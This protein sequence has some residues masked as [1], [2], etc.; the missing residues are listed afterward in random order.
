MRKKLPVFILLFLC[1]VTLLISTIYADVLTGIDGGVGAA[2]ATMISSASTDINIYFGGTKNVFKFIPNDND[3]YT[4]Q[5]N[6]SHD[7]YAELYNNP[8]LTGPIASDDDTG[9]GYNPLITIALTKDTVYYLIIYDYEE[10]NTGTLSITGI[11]GGGL[12]ANNSPTV[13]ITNPTQ[14][15]VY[16]DSQTI[17][18]SG[19]ASDSDGDNV[20][21]SATIN[22]QLA[23]TTVSGGSGTWTLTWNTAS[24]AENIYNNIEFTVDDSFGGSGT[25][26]YTGNITVDKTAPTAAATYSKDPVKQGDSLTITAN[27]S[28]AL[29]DSPKVKIAISGANTVSATDMTKVSET[30]YTYTYTVGTGNG[31]ATV[32]FSTGTDAAG[33]VITAAPTGGANYTI[34]NTGPAAPTINVLSSQPDTAWNDGYLNASEITSSR[35]LRVTLP[36]SGSLAV[37]GDTLYVY[38]DGSQIGSKLLSGTEITNGYV[39]VT[40]SSAT[41][42]GLTEATHTLTAKIIDSVGNTGS[43]SAGVSVTVD[44]TALTAAVTYSKNPVKQGDSLTITANFSKA[45]LDSPVVKIA[46][47]GANTVAA[48]D[49]TKVSETQYTYIYSVGAG[50]GTATVSFSTGTDA[51]GNVIT[52]APTSGANYTIDNT[53][54]TVN[55]LSPENNASS[56]GVTDNLAI[57]FSEN[58]VVGTGNITIKKTT[59]DSTVETIAVTSGKVTGGG[60]S[61]I[62]INP[63]TILAGSTSYYVLI[64]ATTF[65][66]TAGNSYAGISDK[67][68][69]SFITVVPLPP[70]ITFVKPVDGS[71]VNISTGSAII[72][73]LINNG[74]GIDSSSVQLQIDGGAWVN[75]TVL[76]AN[77]QGYSLYYV[78]T[79]INYSTNPHTVTVKV[80]DLVGNPTTKTISFHMDVRRNGFG[81]GRLRFD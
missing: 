11:T 29:L 9:V 58:V 43:T 26:S 18:I 52:G 7:P 47:G 20:S 55:A 75:P 73:N 25:A 64:D 45:L 14:D 68:T 22:G 56:V 76:T 46:V 74:S 48:T 12:R 2:D 10:D 34:D 42:G 67:N 49:M 71:T 72:V 27:F 30:Q 65:D 69:W 57:T 44:K 37:A 35:L 36:T 61:T 66:D 53:A 40:I 33:N 54:P 17:S 62:I 19:S 41:L 15:R 6:S 39:D 1:L 80:K 79:N 32:S 31:T 81:F 23:T 16:K 77:S 13:S 38:S 51:A 70:T 3:T 50:N 78:I 4:I 60:T 5:T 28:E 24:I 59:D 8:S 63:A 21:V